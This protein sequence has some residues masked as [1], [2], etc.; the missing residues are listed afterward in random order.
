MT[1]T[2]LEHHLQDLR[3]AGG[4]KTEPVTQSKCPQH[5][6]DRSCFSLWGRQRHCQR[7]IGCYLLTGCPVGFWSL[8]NLIVLWIFFVFAAG[9]LSLQILLRARLKWASTMLLMSPWK[10]VRMIY[11]GCFSTFTAIVLSIL[12]SMCQL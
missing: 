3:S 1:A 11:W 6:P 5:S 9:A 10:Y 8:P 7:C 4:L 12:F 2:S